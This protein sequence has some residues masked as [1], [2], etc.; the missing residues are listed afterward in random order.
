MI[1]QPSIAFRENGA[2][3]RRQRVFDL[4]IASLALLAASPVLAL[5]ALAIRLE[6]RGPIFFKQKRVGRFGKLF[7]IYKLRTM[8]ITDCGDALSPSAPGDAR[9]TRVGRFLRK[10][11][12]DELPQLINVLRGEMSIV[13][14][15]PEMP[16]VVQQRYEP[17]QHLRHLTKPGVTGLWQI[18]Y[19]SRIPLHRP[20]ATQIDLEYIR[21]ASVSTD[22]RIVLHTFRA[23]LSTQGAY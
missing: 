20:E 16:F 4:T 1:P 5:A 23:L 3:R 11:S 7:T 10:A 9:I 15:R 12:I 8:R 21:T 19:R 18:R 2:Y 22:G 17:W 13:G 14:P 6:D